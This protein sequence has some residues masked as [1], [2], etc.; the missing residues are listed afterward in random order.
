M[1]FERA[2]NPL[3]V[4]LAY[5]NIVFLFLILPNT[6]EEPSTLVIMPRPRYGALS[7]DARLTSV[8]LS[9]T[10]GLSREQ[11]GIG[12]LKLALR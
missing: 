7:D 1:Q 8:C 4:M 12:R 3:F 11:R 9:R 6:M 10:S 2:Y 5:S